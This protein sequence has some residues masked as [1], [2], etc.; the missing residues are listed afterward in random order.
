MVWPSQSIAANMPVAVV[1]KV[2]RR[3]GTETLARAYLEFLYSEP[4]QDIIARN[5]YRPTS[6]T[7]AEKYAAQF[8]QI[9][10]LAVDDIFGGWSNA[11]RFHFA[12][13]GIYDQISSSK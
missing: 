6:R 8:V 2:A 7:I 9:K 10:L 3:N 4:G 13:G 11:Q 5:F 12:D 1:E